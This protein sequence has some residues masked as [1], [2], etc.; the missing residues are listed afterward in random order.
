M[1]LYL[2]YNTATGAYL[3]TMSDGSV[4]WSTSDTPYGLAQSAID[5][6][7]EQGLVVR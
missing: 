1:R 7:R 6:L 3:C 4:Y 2:V 5:E